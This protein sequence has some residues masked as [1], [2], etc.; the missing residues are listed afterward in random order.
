MNNPN[1]RSQLPHQLSHRNQKYTSSVTR[2]SPL[3]P[4]EV[5]DQVVE[6]EVEYHMEEHHSIA[7]L[8]EEDFLVLPYQGRPFPADPSV[9]DLW[10]VIVSEVVPVTDTVALSP[11]QSV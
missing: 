11:A 4:L 7:D 3:H 6:L 2:L 9:V 8:L 5:L 1:F 10:M